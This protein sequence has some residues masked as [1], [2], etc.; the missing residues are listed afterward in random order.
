[1]QCL[2]IHKAGF[3]M[4]QQVYTLTAQCWTGSI[5]LP[6]IPAVFTRQ[7][8]RCSLTAEL[9]VPNEREKLGNIMQCQFCHSSRCHQQGLCRKITTV[10]YLNKGFQKIRIV[11]C[12]ILI[13]MNLLWKKGK[14]PGY[15]LL[16]CA[17]RVR[18]ATFPP[19]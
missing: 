10:T 8:H 19:F 13:G 16:A 17:S 7:C 4:P 9:S 15:L 14:V 11:R 12:H 5:Q 6:K 3:C 18:A 2:P 1:M